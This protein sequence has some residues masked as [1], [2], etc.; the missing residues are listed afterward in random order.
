MKQYKEE[1]NSSV[2]LKLVEYWI[3]GCLILGVGNMFVGSLPWLWLLGLA[4][5]PL[6]L[7]I[8]VCLLAILAFLILVIIASIVVAVDEHKERKHGGRNEGH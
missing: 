3:L 1:K 7:F 8:A 5:L 6:A 4:L 2:I